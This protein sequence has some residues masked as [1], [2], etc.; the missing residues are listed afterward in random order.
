MMIDQGEHVLFVIDGSKG[1]ERKCPSKPLNLTLNCSDS[2]AL[3]VSR[4]EASVGCV[5]INTCGFI[6]KLFFRDC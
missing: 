4:N 2:L 6:V 5:S 1:K 3:S